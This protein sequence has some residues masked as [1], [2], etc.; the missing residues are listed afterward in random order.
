MKSYSLDH[1]AQSVLHRDSLVFH[2]NESDAMAMAIAHVGEI[3]A[4][5]SYRDEGYP[6]ML[7]FCEH[8]YDMSEQAAL[9]RIRVARVAREYPAIFEALATGK[10]SLSGV[11]ML[12]AHLTPANADEL[13]A[14]ATHVPKSELGQLIVK[15]FP[16][17]DVP[18]KLEAVAGPPPMLGDQL[19]PG[20]VGTAIAGQLSAQPAGATPDDQL[21][22]RDVDTTIPRTMLSPL[23]ADR[24]V[25]QLTVSRCTHDKL[26][27]AQELLSH[28]LPSGDMAEVFDR[29]LDALIMKLERGKFAATSRPRA[30]RHCTSTNP[31]H[32]PS[33]VKREV[34][35]RDGGQCTFVSESGHR[36]EARKFLE[37][38][39][40]EAVALGGKAS[41][42]GMR[43]RCRAHNQ[44][45]AERMFGAE[46]MQ[47]KREE[48]QRVAR[49]QQ[50]AKA[51]A[52]QI[53]AESQ[54]ATE[55]TAPESSVTAAQVEAEVDARIAATER[56]AETEQATAAATHAKELDVIP[57]L[58]ALGF[59]LDDA[60]RA[61]AHCV[62]IPDAS[63]EERVRRALAFLAPR[64]TKQGFRR[65]EHREGASV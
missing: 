2:R 47:A 22:S 13:I 3:D 43:L 31:R 48:A 57:W 44:F 33:H 12:T 19:S 21:C 24:F 1:L 45:E 52:E 60:R 17:P 15:W 59:R 26:R 10:L 55:A 27:Y 35:V 8:V 58:R 16:K 14:A 56:A 36:C 29:A 41:V 5:R 32:I 42:S 20:S 34:W 4:R 23:S 25:L 6:S 62:T 7:A 63:L 64:A 11:I 38:D 53:A 39:H 50:A 30:A 37:F 65:A 49:E 61:A 54:V 28:R 18:A 40:I 46:F 9:K 51:A